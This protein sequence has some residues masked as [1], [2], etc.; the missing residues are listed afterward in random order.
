MPS[1]VIDYEIHGDDMQFVEITLDP[2]ETVIAEAGAMMYMR[3]DIH[4][5]T[6]MGDGSDPDEGFL[7]KVFSVGKRVFTGESLFMTHF[8]AQGSA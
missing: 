6:R 1:H 8:T 5:D 7:S 4:M 2:Q 3:P